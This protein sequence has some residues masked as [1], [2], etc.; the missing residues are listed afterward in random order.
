MKRVCSI[1]DK[2]EL[3]CRRSPEAL[4]QRFL[5]TGLLRGSVWSFFFASLVFFCLFLLTSSWF[6]LVFLLFS[7]T[8]FFSSPFS[9]CLTSVSDFL[10][11]LVREPFFFFGDPS[12]LHATRT[13]LHLSTSSTRPQRHRHT[14]TVCERGLTEQPNTE[15]ERDCATKDPQPPRN[16]TQPWSFFVFR[17]LFPAKALPLAVPCLTHT[18][19]RN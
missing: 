6:F 7:P 16:A 11:L 3:H 1:H 10:P 18:G 4:V 15:K 2:T 8:Q 9:L 12:L 5:T 17:D 14:H 19:P 13:P